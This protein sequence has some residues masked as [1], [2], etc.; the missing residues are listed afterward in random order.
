[1]EYESI[2]NCIINDSD[3][4]TKIDTDLLQNCS[5]LNV[6]DFTIL[7]LIGKGSY[8]KVFLVKKNGSDEILAM[9]TLKKKDMKIR[10]QELHIKTE[11]KIMEMINHPFI[12]KLR[13][14]FQNN[15][16]L[17]LISDFCQGGELFYHM[18]KIGRF[19]VKATKFYVAQIVLALEHLHSLD[20]IYR[21]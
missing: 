18:Q 20:I 8:G 15:K 11:R 9:K 5:K 2:D 10:H 4:T 3:I 13:Y 19:N 21:E 7:K 16:K 17:Y 14:A 1:M 6:D 12:I